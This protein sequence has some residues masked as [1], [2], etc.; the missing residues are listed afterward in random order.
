[1][2]GPVLPPQCPPL[3]P[4]ATDAGRPSHV[5]EPRLDCGQREEAVEYAALLLLDVLCTI[6]VFNLAAVVRGLGWQSGLMLEALT[7][8][9]AITVPKSGCSRTMPRKTPVTTNAGA[10]PRWAS[11][12]SVFRLLR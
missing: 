10:R 4:L 1:M 6:G 3:A 7:A 2:F 9:I 5:V 12:M 11:W 8:P